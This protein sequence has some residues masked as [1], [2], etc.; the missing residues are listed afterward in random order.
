MPETDW[1][2]AL[3]ILIFCYILCAT[4]FWFVHEKV[5]KQLQVPLLICFVPVYMLPYLGHGLLLFGVL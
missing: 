5:A 4:L 2:S 1:T 3:Y